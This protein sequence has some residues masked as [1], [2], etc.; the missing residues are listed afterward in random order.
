MNNNKPKVSFSEAATHLSVICDKIDDNPETIDALIVNEFEDALSD[1]TASVDRRKAFYRELVYKIEMAVQFQH[2]IS[3]HIER[4][5]RIKDR[6]IEVTKQVIEANPGMPFKDSFG[7]QLK[8]IDNPT[9][10][11]IIEDEVWEA[12]DIVS[13]Y[14]KE[15]LTK[16]WDKNKIKEDLLAGKKL[17]FARL[18]Y[19][20][21][22]R[23]MK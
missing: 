3:K 8:V 10:K 6:L 5:R 7:K 20:K 1:V 21:Q 2:E 4:Y 11:L 23:G 12:N 16:E 14:Q 17:S 15:I 9:P 19:G 18:E 22:L 13:P